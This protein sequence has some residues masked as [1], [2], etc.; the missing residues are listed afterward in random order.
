MSN[1]N[2]DLYIKKMSM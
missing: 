2:L 1:F